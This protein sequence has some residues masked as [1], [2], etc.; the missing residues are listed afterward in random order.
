MKASLFCIHIVCLLGYA[1][2]GRA[3][4]VLVPNGL[5]ATDGN[6]GN[7]YP[8]IIGT[9]TAIYQQVYEASQF[10]SIAPVGGTISAITFR[11]NASS[12][13]WGIQTLPDLEIRLS[14]TVKGPD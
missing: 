14:T 8:F 13:G 1:L 3:A 4:F 7:I 2:S 12:P 5:E 6:A 9:N 11:L 10:R